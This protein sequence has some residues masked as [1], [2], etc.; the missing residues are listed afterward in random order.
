VAFLDAINPQ[1]LLERVRPVLGSR[2]RAVVIGGGA[3]LAT[4][5]AL[6]V[7]WLW[8]S[9]YAVLY[10]GLSGEEGGRAI[11]ELQKLNIPYR[12][13]EGGRVIQVPA[14]EV[15]RARLQLAARGVA[16]RDSDEWAILDNQSLGVSPFV[17]QVHYI[18]GIEAGL[19][20]TIGEV[21]G[22]ISAKVTLA[23]PKQTDFLG[24]SPKPSGSVLVRLRPGTV[25]SGG[26]V[27]G[28]IGLVASSVPGLA[29]EQVTVIDQSGAVLNPTS[30]DVALQAQQFETAREINH[31]YETL[32]TDLLVPI[33]GRG[34]FRVSS[35]ADIDFSQSKESHVKY[36]DSHVLSQD[37]TIH[38][39]GAGGD[40]AIGIPGALSNRRPE[41]PT[42]EAARPPAQNAPQTPP[43]G[44]DA[45]AAQTPPATPA[46]PAAAPPPS[47]THRTTNYDIDKTVQFL[48]HPSWQLRGINIA[49][50]VNNPTGSPIP[51]ERLQSI[52]KLVSSAIGVGQNPHVTVVD[53]P[54]EAPDGGGIEPVGPWWRAP[55]MAAVGQNALLAVAGIFALFGGVFPLLRRLSAA[56]VAVVAAAKRAVEVRTASAD[57]GGAAGGL[58]GPATAADMLR[59][60]GLRVTNEPQDVFAIEA[61]TV[62]TLVTHDPARTAQVI[63][64]WIAGDRSSLK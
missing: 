38:T 44:Q 5:L 27:S 19:S 2:T 14:A 47:D 62:Q 15:G 21:D 20:R 30:K 12:I 11:A 22:V 33:L 57:G 7:L 3:G 25:L 23:I 61:E 63:R 28:I 51:A 8:G 1:A 18:R 55:W 39:R 50:L 46:P 37:E 56:Q 45:A 26:Q 13:A 64:G 9:S 10:A 16:K 43:A 4:V 24:D 60:G 49:V 59:T 36:G 32:L 52:D 53:L 29:R 48:E 6:A 40:E 58:G 35:D 42:T 34:N 17:E 31:R 54:F 41:N